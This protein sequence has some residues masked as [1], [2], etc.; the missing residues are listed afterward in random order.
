M[1]LLRKYKTIIEPLV[2]FIIL[3]FIFFPSFLAI[4]LEVF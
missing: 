4:Y 1:I 2:L 3:R